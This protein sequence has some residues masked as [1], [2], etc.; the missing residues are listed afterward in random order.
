MICRGN[1]KDGEYFFSVAVIWGK[2]LFLG[3]FIVL[4]RYKTQKGIH[5]Q[6]IMCFY[7]KIMNMAALLG[8]PLVHFSNLTH[9]IFLFVSLVIKLECPN[10]QGYAAVFWVGILWY[11]TSIA[12][13]RP[14]CLG[15]AVMFAW[16]LTVCVMSVLYHILPGMVAA[17]L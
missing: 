2:N 13:P 8:W 16:V 4:V 12:I 15:Q 14:T 10:P 6:W 1:N 7:L 11:C 9:S 17:R 3:V 5:Q